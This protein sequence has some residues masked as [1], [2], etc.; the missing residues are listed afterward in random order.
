QSTEHR[1]S[2]KAAK[3]TPARRIP[4]AVPTPA[5]SEFYAAMSA[6][7]QF[8]PGKQPNLAFQTSIANCSSMF[9]SL[10]ANERDPIILKLL[11]EI[12]AALQS[13]QNL[14]Y[15]RSSLI[16]L[17]PAIRRMAAVVSTFPP[18]RLY[19]HRLPADRYLSQPM[20]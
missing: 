14:T 3:P 16:A 9:L 1:A 17:T 13:C 15:D 18:T 19:R 12:S 10:A 4:L 11:R 7:V 5:F 2:P 6:E 8:S 20:Q